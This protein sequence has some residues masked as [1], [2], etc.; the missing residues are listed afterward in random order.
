LEL[1][2]LDLKGPLRLGVDDGFL[3]FLFQEAIRLK[4]RKS[5]NSLALAAS[6]PPDLPMVRIGG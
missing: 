2:E 6:C 5:D 4:N 1:Q 3:G